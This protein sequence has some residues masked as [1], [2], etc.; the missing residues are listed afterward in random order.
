MEPSDQIALWAVRAGL[1]VAGLGWW[2]WTQRLLGRRPWPATA[3]GDAIHDWTDALNRFLATHV[4][5]ADALLVTSSAVIDGL[6]LVVPASAI[7]GPSI[8]PFLGLLI[9]YALRQ[10][11]QGLCAFS[12]PPGMIWRHPG[13]P[14]LL[15][16]YGTATDLFFSG[17]TAIAVYGAIELGR[18]GGPWMIPLG[19]AIVLFEAG[20]VLVLRAHSTADVFAAIVAALWAASVADLLAPALDRAL[21]TVLALA[22]RLAG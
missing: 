8:R 16:T 4:R 9:V 7:F 18:L 12:P 21:A 3:I 10:L 22:V 1:V 17:H 5:A 19:V 11:C 15:V 20:A 13:F 6:G 14:S 2:F